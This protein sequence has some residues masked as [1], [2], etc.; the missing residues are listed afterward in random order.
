MAQP[1]DA[2]H[3]EPDREDAITRSWVKD[4]SPYMQITAVGARAD[5]PAPTPNGLVDR[6]HD[7]ENREPL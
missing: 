4:T 1:T 5:T 7:D 2:P 3:P 6:R